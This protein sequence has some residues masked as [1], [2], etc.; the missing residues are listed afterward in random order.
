MAS[1]RHNQLLQAKLELANLQLNLP[2]SLLNVRIMPFNTPAECGNIAAGILQAEILF[3]DGQKDSAIAVF[4][5]TASS[6]DKL[7]Y[8]EPQQWLIPTRQ[9][10][11]KYLLKMDRVAEA[12]RVYRKDLDRNPGDGWSLLGLYQSLVAQRRIEQ[13]KSVKTKYLQAFAESD[14]NPSASAF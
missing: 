10:L 14:V 12:E 11:G 3:A 4:N 13:A 8:R 6:E 5:H 2:D 1:V 9:Y 7:I